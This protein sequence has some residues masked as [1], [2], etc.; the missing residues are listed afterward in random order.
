M[1]VRNKARARFTVVVGSLICLGFSPATA[2]AQGKPEPVALHEAEILIYLLPEA[3]QIRSEGMEIGWEVSTS[4]KLNQDDYFTFWVY[5]AKRK[6]TGSVTVGH[7]AVNKHTADVWDSV[8]DK[9]ISTNELQGVQKILRK[10]HRI[11]EETIKKY[12]FRSL[13]AMGRKEVRTAS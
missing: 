8:L 2:T 13:S 6:G 9:I 5:S 7:F 3:H 4:P 12:R 10:G 11:D 1:C